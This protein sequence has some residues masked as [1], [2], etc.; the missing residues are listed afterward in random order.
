MN[1]CITPKEELW[2]YVCSNP[3][4]SGFPIMSGDNDSCNNSSE[5]SARKAHDSMRSRPSL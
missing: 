1:A 4:Y 2:I 5:V 3:D